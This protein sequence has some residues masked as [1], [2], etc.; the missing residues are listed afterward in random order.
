M[1]AASSKS[2]HTPHDEVVHLRD[3][4]DRANTAYYCDA[5]PIMADS[6]YDRQLKRLADL[7]AA[8][9]ELADPA[10]PTRRV[11]GAPIDSFTPVQHARPMQSIDNTYDIEG[12]RSWTARC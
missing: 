8:H 4:L 5:D 3:L 6:E 2:W 12:L 10:S 1:S 7:E 9:P 11:G